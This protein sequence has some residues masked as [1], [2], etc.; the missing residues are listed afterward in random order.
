MIGESEFYAGAH[1]DQRFHLLRLREKSEI[2]ERLIHVF[3]S[4]SA[5]QSDA[6][7]RRGVRPET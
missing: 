7:A 3:T 2:A 5:K 1:A 4:C 6:C